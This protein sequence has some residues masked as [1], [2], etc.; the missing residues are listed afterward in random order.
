MAEVWSIKGI[1]PAERET[2]TRG[3]EAAGVPIGRYIVHACVALDATQPMP[4]RETEEAWR[5]F[6]RM[7]RLAVE[8][9]DHRD[10]PARAARRLLRAGI[11]AEGGRLF[12]GPGTAPGRPETF[13]EGK[14]NTVL[15]IVKE[16]AG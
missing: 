7:V 14:A 8:L 15:S 4:A 11:E 5:R 2:I 16:G 3:A 1:S 10:G 9:R 13:I 6:E 12:P